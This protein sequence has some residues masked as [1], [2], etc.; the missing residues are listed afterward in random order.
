MTKLNT[1]ITEPNVEGLPF[2]P[3]PGSK[4]EMWIC[5]VCKTKNVDKQSK[6]CIN[7]GRDAWGNPGT[8]PPD[9]P[10]RPALRG[11]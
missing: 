10:H 9:K 4:G 11:D 6:L 3:R 8:I 5:V 7:C 1:E 2:I